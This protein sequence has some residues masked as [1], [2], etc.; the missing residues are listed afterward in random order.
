[1]MADYRYN[2]NDDF[3]PDEVIEPMIIP[4]DDEDEEDEYEDD[5]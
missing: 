1:M 3:W 4:E 5:D 2:P